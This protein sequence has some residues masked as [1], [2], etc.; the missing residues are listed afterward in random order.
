M[1]PVAS[2]TAKE[3]CTIFVSTVDLINGVEKECMSETLN[4]YSDLTLYF[5]DEQLKHFTLIIIIIGITVAILF[6]VI[7]KRYI[8][9]NIKVRREREF[10]DEEYILNFG[11]SKV[12]YMELVDKFNQAGKLNTRLELLQSEISNINFPGAHKSL[13]VQLKKT[14]S[15]FESITSDVMEKYIRLMS[16]PAEEYSKTQL[17]RRASKRGVESVEEL[18]KWLH[19]SYAIKVEI[20]RKNTR[21]RLLQSITV[22]LTI[23]GEISYLVKRLEKPLYD[24]V[25]QNHPHLMVDVMSSLRCNYPDYY[26]PNPNLNSSCPLSKLQ[27][28]DH[29]GSSLQPTFLKYDNSQHQDNNNNNN[30]NEHI[31]NNDQMGNEKI[32]IERIIKPNQIDELIEKWKIFFVDQKNAETAKT[33]RNSQKVRQ[34]LSNQLRT[35]FGSSSENLI[36]RFEDPEQFKSAQNIKHISKQTQC[37]FANQAVVWGN[38]S[39]PFESS[40]NGDDIVEHDCESGFD[41][42][43]ASFEHETPDVIIEKILDS[44]IFFKPSLP[45]LIRLCLVCVF[46]FPLR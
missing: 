26:N 8:T 34:L 29:E 35:I 42:L 21:E 14:L 33:K 40:I 7:S 9:T 2:P 25:M 43:I 44:F 31:T 19:Q 46:L 20:T 6:V 12:D 27:S 16:F 45:Y 24:A 30:Y 11:V 18:E 10:K 28:T 38:P 13:K 41:D 39:H 22:L 37:I 3:D 4:S 36:W 32:K 1:E 5:F 23:L 15:E 17:T